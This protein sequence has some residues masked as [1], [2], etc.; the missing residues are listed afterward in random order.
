MND[1]IVPHILNMTT[2]NKIGNK[3]EVENAKL[4]GIQEVSERL[5]VSSNTLYC[6]I[7]QRRIPHFKVGRLVKFDGV[8]IDRWIAEKH[9][10]AEEFD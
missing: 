6:W 4:I 1:A 3:R 2:H 7:S 8:E 9:V 10:P 5:G